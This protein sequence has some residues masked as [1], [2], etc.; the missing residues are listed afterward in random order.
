MSS[1]NL[2]LGCLKNLVEMC[3]QEGLSK[4]AP[5]SVMVRF[6]EIPYSEEADGSRNYDAFNKMS[7]SVGAGVDPEKGCLLMAKASNESG[8]IDVTDVLTQP[9]I[10]ELQAKGIIEMLGEVVDQSTTIDGNIDPLDITKYVETKL[11]PKIN[12]KS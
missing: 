11:I 4:D 8:L 5:I 2:T 9:Q 7:L 10:L 6:D 3:E 1:E 12:P